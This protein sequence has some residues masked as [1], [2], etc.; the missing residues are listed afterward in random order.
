[1]KIIC[2]GKNYVK[3]IQELNGSFDDNPTI[4]MKPD[5]SIIQKNQP[6]F[7]PEF[8]DE[9]HYELELILKFSKVGKHIDKD[10]C[11]NYISHF[12]LGIDFTARDL[13]NDLK[14]KGLPWE[15]SKS[16]TLGELAQIVSLIPAR[17][18]HGQRRLASARRLIFLGD[19]G[20]TF[21]R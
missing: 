9:I 20:G 6:F 16:F 17:V 21:A 3:H 7:I 13:Q 11:L 19:R 18:Q 10:F 12:S 5:S 15:I 1:M 14:L 4:F 2:I 8:S